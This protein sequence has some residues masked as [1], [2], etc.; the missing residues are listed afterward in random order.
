MTILE[1]Y[2]LQQAGKTD[3]PEYQNFM[4]FRHRHNQW[5]CSACGASVLKFGMVGTWSGQPLE[6]I[7]W[8]CPD[9]QRG[10]GL[11]V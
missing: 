2:A 7:E 6:E 8:L 10:R 3:D 4:A 9:C 11:A 5:P 1:A